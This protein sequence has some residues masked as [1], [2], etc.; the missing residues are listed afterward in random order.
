MN[1]TRLNQHPDRSIRI[2]GSIYMN[3]TKPKNN[4]IHFKHEQ[5]SNTPI[6]WISEHF[7]WCC[8]ACIYI[9][10]K[11]SILRSLRTL[12]V[13]IYFSLV[14]RWKYHFHWA[15]NQIIYDRFSWSMS[16]YFSIQNWI[17]LWFRRLTACLRR[18]N[19]SMKSILKISSTF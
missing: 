13:C 1:E 7:L 17:Y 9:I 19:I 3:R 12:S 10:W 6:S 4:N 2:D 18:K 5:S 8:M 14:A 11:I 16:G 15:Q